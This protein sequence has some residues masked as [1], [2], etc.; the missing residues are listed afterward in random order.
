MKRTTRLLILFFCFSLVSCGHK[1]KNS[2]HERIEIDFNKVNVI[3]IKN[4]PLGNDK[5]EAKLK[6]LTTEQSK[7]FVDIWNTSESIGLCKSGIQYWIIV[8]FKDGSKRT[9]RVNRQIIKEN[10]DNGYSIKDEKFFDNLW[11][12]SS[13][14]SNKS[15]NSN[16][17][18]E[19]I[20][21]TCAI[22]I[23]PTNKKIEKLKSENKDDFYT[24]ADDNLYCISNARIF[25]DSIKVKTYEV[26]AIGT[27]QFKFENGNISTIDLNK[28]DWGILLFDGKTNPKEI[29]MTVI[30]DEY[31]KYM[32]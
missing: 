16:L 3:E 27:L 7:Q 17:N 21:A 32:K 13:L 31:Q 18:P 10:N 22:I 26:E 6:Q 14:E 29:D 4:N 9:F 2:S 5:T 19:L 28:F 25:L 30:E 12:K 11:N 15:K 23:S 20:S 1:T 24:I 8:T